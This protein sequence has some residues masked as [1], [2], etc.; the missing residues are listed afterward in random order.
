MD[1]LLP[2]AEDSQ[3]GRHEERLRLLTG[4]QRKAL[5]HALEFPKLERL[6]Y[7]TCSVRLAIPSEKLE[8][9]CIEVYERQIKPWQARESDSGNAPGFPQNTRTEP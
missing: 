5:A 4:F 6:V 7:S 8:R 1:D 3:K 2:S 9:V